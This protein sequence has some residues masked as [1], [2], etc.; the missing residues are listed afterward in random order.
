MGELKLVA[1]VYTPFVI[2]F[3]V[4]SYYWNYLVK[5]TMAN[6]KKLLLGIL[7]HKICLFLNFCPLSLR[8]KFYVYNHE[9]LVRF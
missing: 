6:K 2:M 7:L 4:L 1:I 3:G 5:N 8:E 9:S